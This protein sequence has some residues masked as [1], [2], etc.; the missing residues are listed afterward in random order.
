MICDIHNIP[1]PKKT[2]KFMGHIVIGETMISIP[3][4][5]QKNAD[6]D[7]ILNALVFE[8]SENSQFYWEEMES[9]DD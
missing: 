5:T 9:N 1:K 4:E 3:F 8:F 6:D 2:R 7:D